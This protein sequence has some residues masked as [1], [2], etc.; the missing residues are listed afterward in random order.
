MGARAPKFSVTGFHDSVV[1]KE[2]PNFDSACHEPVIREI[3]T[4]PRRTSTRMAEAR[5]AAR[6]TMSVKAKRRTVASLVRTADDITA[7]ETAVISP[8]AFRP[9]HSERDRRAPEAPS[10]VRQNYMPE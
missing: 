4:P 6:K 8:L 2:K 10:L 9:T 3:A 7:S 1:R 5:V